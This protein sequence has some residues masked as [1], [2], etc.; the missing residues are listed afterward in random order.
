MQVA[1]A[2]CAAHLECRVV[3]MN[4][5]TDGKHYLMSAQVLRS[6]VHPD[7]WNDKHFVPSSPSIPALLSFLGA[8]RFAYVR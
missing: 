8:S 3:S 6:W 5:S 2:G 7:Y 1:V 4:E